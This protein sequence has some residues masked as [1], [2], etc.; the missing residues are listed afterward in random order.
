MIKKS[1]TNL[2]RKLSLF[3]FSMINED[4]FVLEPK[5]DFNKQ[6][7]KD[8]FSKLYADHLSKLESTDSTPHFEGE[9]STKGA[10]QF[11]QRNKQSRQIVIP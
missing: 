2:L 9:Y 4:S 11:R 1:A 10:Q 7:R 6:N 3:R 5:D 8:I